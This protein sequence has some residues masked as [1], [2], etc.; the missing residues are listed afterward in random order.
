[1]YSTKYANSTATIPNCCTYSDKYIN[2]NDCCGKLF[3]TKQYVRIPWIII[4]NEGY[5]KFHLHTTII[6]YSIIPRYS[7]ISIVKI[8]V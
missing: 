1:M 8:N 2:C 3:D 7:Y 6:I 5:E 4:L